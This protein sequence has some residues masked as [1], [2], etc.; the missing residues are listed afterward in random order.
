MIFQ[1]SRKPKI[2]NP[3]FIRILEFKNDNK[4]LI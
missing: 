1:D 2:K 3:Y 4:K